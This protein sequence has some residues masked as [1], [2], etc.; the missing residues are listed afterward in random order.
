MREGRFQQISRDVVRRLGRASTVM[1]N[2]RVVSLLSFGEKE[3]SRGRQSWAERREGDREARLGILQE[4]PSK[5]KE[6]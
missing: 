2:T 5:A 4:A 1:H 6:S 3:G